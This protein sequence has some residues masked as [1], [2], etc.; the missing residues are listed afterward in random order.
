M[1]LLSP[2]SKIKENK[3]NKI[4]P[5]RKYNRVQSIVYNSDTLT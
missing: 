5:K 3:K 4:K 1:P 2:K